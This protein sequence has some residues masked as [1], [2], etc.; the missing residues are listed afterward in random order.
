MYDGC[1]SGFGN[2]NPAKK[3]RIII[4]TDA[5]E[6]SITFPNVDHVIGELKF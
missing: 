2:G 1:D 4:A 5:A 3:V 6:S